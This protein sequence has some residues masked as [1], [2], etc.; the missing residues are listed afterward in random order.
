MNT[1]SWLAVAVSAAA[2][3][4]AG[5]AGP[6]HELQA[7]VYVVDAANGE[8]ADANPGTEAKPWKTIQHAADTAQAGDTV[9]VM[10]GRYA[11]RVTLKKSGAAGQPITFRGVPRRA[12]EVQGFATGPAAYV[13]IESFAITAPKSRAAGIEIGGDHVEVLDNYLHDLAL[14]IAPGSSS[15]GASAASPAH[16]RIAYNDVY[17]CQ[18]GIWVGGSRWV[19]ECNHVHRAL[20]LG[21]WGD[22]DYTRVFGTD[23]IVR[24]NTFGGSKKDEIGPAHLDC[25]Q[26]FDSNGEVGKRIEVCYNVEHDFHQG[27]MGECKKTQDNVSDWTFHH[28][29]A[30]CPGS[31]QGFV[32]GAWGLCAVGIPRV[33]VLNSTYY[34]I[35]WYG[36]G[37]T[38][39]KAEGGVIRNNI[40]QKIDE[41]LKTKDAAPTQDHNIVFQCG[42]RD[43]GSKNL[44]DVDPKMVD[45]EKGN[46]RLQKG[47]P[48]IGA[49]E[50][51]ATI[52][53]L[54]YPNVYYVDP[55]HP[56]ATDDGFGYP[57]QPYQTL[58]KALEVAQ[59][60]ETV[61]LRGGVYRETLAP[62]NDGVTVKAL[63]GERVVI[64]GADVIA[65]WKRDG[66]AWLAPLAVEPKKVLRDG[67]PWSEFSYDAAAKRIALKFAGDPRVH[68]FEAVVRQQ[69]IDLGGRKNVKVEEITAENMLK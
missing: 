67:Q 56:A 44:V 21:V 4:A 24:Y 11:E 48:A 47:S 37:I 10:E 51:G 16:I 19:L 57:G 69:P 26:V 31:A 39:K 35:K 23:H 12:A 53:A 63:K 42:K 68:L 58:A 18:E 17:Q 9:C 49:G 6:G 13:R 43:V 40:F 5:A 64:S 7:A 52:G 8:A 50:G 14:G 66:A 20:W 62:K 46:F 27:L 1:M 28:N 29:I 45:P 2:L 38:E 54:E 3:C 33:Q 55:R 60:G 32:E 65:G 59:A 34:S 30:S 61:I 41:A 22:A 25:L 15:S 36:V